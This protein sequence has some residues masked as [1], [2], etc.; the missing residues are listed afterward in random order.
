MILALPQTWSHGL[1]WAPIAVYQTLIVSHIISET[2]RLNVITPFTPIQFCG[3]CYTLIQTHSYEQRSV[4]CKR[5]YYRRM[6]RAWIRRYHSQLRK[7][8]P[9]ENRLAN[10][11]THTRA[12]EIVR[13]WIDVLFFHL[14]IEFNLLEMSCAQR[15]QSQSWTKTHIA[16]ALNFFYFLFALLRLR[17]AVKQKWRQIERVSAVIRGIW[18]QFDASALRTCRLRA[19]LI[20]Q[21]NRFELWYAREFYSTFSL[22][23]SRSLHTRQRTK[24]MQTRLCNLC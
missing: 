1:S 4:S 3:H 13:N 23:H 6:P 16:N 18:R 22:M 11:H 2:D 8:F 21:I 14:F 10:K 15:T 20:L 5:F 7:D 17:R 9:C 12:C 19:A 24:A